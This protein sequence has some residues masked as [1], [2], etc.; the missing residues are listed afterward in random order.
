MTNYMELLMTG[1]PWNL[2]AFMVLPVAMAE[3]ITMAEF[4]ILSDEHRYAGWKNLSHYLGMIL[5]I[6]FI[7]IFVYLAFVVVPN[8]EFRGWIDM[9]AVGFYMLGVIPLALIALQEAGIIS[10]NFSVKQK[11]NRHIALL[12]TFL[13]VSHVAMVFG[14]VDP[15]LGGWQPSAQ[16]DMMNHE[17]GAMSSMDDSHMSSHKM[18]H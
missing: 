1:Q 14:M 7:G 13:I 17:G 3:L 8:I 4:F 15:A 2:I 18:K 12:V 9:L 16:Y 5:G 6:Y 10:R 11:L